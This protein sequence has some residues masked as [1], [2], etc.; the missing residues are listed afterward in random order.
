[1]GMFT[2]VNWLFSGGEHSFSI[3]LDWRTF[4]LF[5]VA[6]FLLVNFEKLIFHIWGLANYIGNKCLPSAKSAAVR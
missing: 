6:A 4:S 1:M 5:V 3:D 2:I